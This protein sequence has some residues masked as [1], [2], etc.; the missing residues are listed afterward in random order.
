MAATRCHRRRRRREMG[1]GRRTKAEPQIS[2][3][4][5]S[6][7]MRTAG[8][9]RRHRKRATVWVS[10]GK[11]EGAQGAGPVGI[12]CS[13][14]WRMATMSSRRHG[15]RTRALTTCSV[16]IPWSCRWGIA[17][18]GRRKPPAITIRR[19]V[20]GLHTPT[21]AKLSTKARVGKRKTKCCLGG[22]VHRRTK[23]QE[24]RGRKM[25]NGPTKV[26][27][28]SLNVLPMASETVCTPWI[29]IRFCRSM[30]R[31]MVLFFSVSE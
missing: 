16:G 5:R 2:I 19:Q 22:K 9:S 20:Q 14:R 30:G 26:N 17:T 7:A 29:P 3:R 31:A 11:Q 12:P 6:R 28:A 15:Q 1:T 23:P 25:T 18:M 24:A 10:V 8:S 13:C 21:L 4:V 27:G